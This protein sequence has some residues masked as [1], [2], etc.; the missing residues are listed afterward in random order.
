MEIGKQG[1]SIGKSG[2]K[3]DI[4]I[5][6]NPSVSRKHAQIT[7]QRQKYYIRD[8]GSANGTFINGKKLEKEEEYPLQSEDQVVFA[9]VCYRFVKNR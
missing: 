8:L 1:M 7:W 3:A 4:V 5:E 2:T 9:D 6:G